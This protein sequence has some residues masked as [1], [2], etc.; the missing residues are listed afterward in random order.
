M[1]TKKLKQKS[2]YRDFNFQFLAHPITGDLVMLN[3]VQ[4]VIQSIRNLVL[5]VAGEFL[6]EPNIGGGVS[7]LL[8]ELNVPLMKLHIFDRLKNVIER[9]EK[10]VELESL[11]V[12]DIAE[13]YGVSITITFYM[14]NNPVAITETIPLIR[15]R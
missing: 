12:N 7:K 3:D 11:V 8:F 4:S 14:L 6:W 9:F 2:V 10:R 5:T 15:T 13:G 1:A